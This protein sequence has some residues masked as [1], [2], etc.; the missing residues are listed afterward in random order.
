MTL[1]QRTIDP[2]VHRLERAMETGASRDEVSEALAIA[3]QADATAASDGDSV[4]PPL[5]KYRAT[6]YVQAERM[7]ER[8]RLLFVV[9][10]VIFSFAAVVG[11]FGLATLDRMRSLVDHQ[12]EFD[13]L[14]QAEQWDQASVYL[15]ALDEQTQKE[16]AFVRGR[17]IVD[18]AIT[19]EAERKAEF[20]R[21]SSELLRENLADLDPQQVDKLVNLA[22]SD[23]EREIASQV[24]DKLDEQRLR[25][26]AARANDQTL[27]FEALQK[28]VDQFLSV[29]SSTL[30]EKERDTRRFEL[31]QEMGRFVS[32]NQFGNPELAAAAKQ[33]VKMLA[34]TADR[35]RQQS[36]RD[37]LLGE[38]TKSIGDA[39]RFV[40][41]LE[42]FMHQLPN[43][44][45]SKLL[46]QRLPSTSNI[47]ATLAW[48]AVMEH[49]GFRQPRTVDSAIAGDWL[50]HAER[51]EMMGPEHPFA[52]IALTWKDRYQCIAGCD[53]VIKQL[54]DEFQSDLLKRMYVYPAPDGQTFFS[55]QPPSDD[56][57]RAHL[58]PVFL[59][60]TLQVE[61]KNFGLR[62]RENVLPNVRI[63]GHSQY[64]EKMSPI[65]ASANA[66]DFTPVA[67]RLINE[68]RTFQSDPEIQPVYQ[69]I[70]M[71]RL[72][73]L[74]TQG[75][76]PI[77]DAFGDWLESLDASS[78]AWDFNWMRPNQDDPDL[79]QQSSQ[80]KRLIVLEDWDQRVDKMLGSFKS[81][82]NTRPAAPRWVGWVSHGASQFQAEL[83]EE[84][85]SENLYVLSVDDQTGKTKMVWIGTAEESNPIIVTDPDAQQCGAMICIVP[86]MK[87]STP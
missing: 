12:T 64:A 43:D 22:R 79:S 54:R 10:G 30:A 71:R 55:S 13:R 16:T 68:L 3:E 65:L 42:R 81:F 21:L 62:F 17:E 23:E 9:A 6:E 66:T 24:S 67:Y 15:N 31:Q 76:V 39:D 85:N 80:A 14:V 57:D 47:N 61:T 8:R 86:G 28:K 87:P 51:A 33:T 40:A 19:R 53:D 77:R 11:G 74:A 50:T 56:S 70:L 69:L 82:R 78:F 48:I 20:K 59:D 7:L 41:A 49:G 44:T 26:E 36:G 4:L 35:K 38:I 29:E 1:I 18:Q 25:R 73:T 37:Q 27:Q 75:S 58:V 5:L 72:L 34:A 32:D 52:D 84:T 2:V 46:Q 45:T 83:A 60:P 63:A